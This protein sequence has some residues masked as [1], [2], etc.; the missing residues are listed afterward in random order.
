VIAIESVHAELGAVVAGVKPGRV[1]AEEVIV[2][3]ST[4]MALHDAVA[5]AAVYK[6]VIALDRGT[7]VNF[8]E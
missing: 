8:S 6:R 3:D 2:F 4:G 7:L 1:S 5:G